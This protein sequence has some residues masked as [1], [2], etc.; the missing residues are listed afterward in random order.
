M[1]IHLRFLLSTFFLLWPLRSL[2]F[3]SAVSTEFTLSQ[4]A[5]Y[6][7]SCH[8]GVSGAPLHRSH[9][10]D[11]D[12]LMAQSNSRGKLK[13]PAML[14]PAVYLK[15]G[16]IVCTSCHHPESQQIGKLVITSVGSKLCFACHNL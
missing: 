7:L 14:D 8:G 9:P 5:T 4:G 12:Y 15:D 11:I 6:C 13:P 10:V 2:A 16:Q 3:D 1:P